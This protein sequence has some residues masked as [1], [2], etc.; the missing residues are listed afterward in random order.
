MAAPGC[1]AA[2]LRMKLFTKSVKSAAEWS[3]QRRIVWGRGTAVA[4]AVHAMSSRG[5]PGLCRVFCRSPFRFRS[6]SVPCPFRVNGTD[7]KVYFSMTHT[8][9]TARCAKNMINDLTIVTSEISSRSRLRLQSIKRHE[10]SAAHKDSV[11]MEEVV[12][13]IS[14]SD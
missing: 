4:A 10:C 11:K 12:G 2:F 6:V 5:F 14:G 7:E 9:C 8:V 3:N 1:M 13:C